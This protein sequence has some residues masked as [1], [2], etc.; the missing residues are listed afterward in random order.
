MKQTAIPSRFIST[1][2]INAI[3]WPGRVRTG[4]MSSSTGPMVATWPACAT[5][6][7]KPSSSSS[8]PKAS[9][10]GPSLWCSSGC[11]GCSICAPI[12]WSGLSM[13]QEIMC[14]GLSSMHFFCFRR[15][16]WSD[17]TFR[18]SA[19]FHPASV[20]AP[21]Q[22]SRPWRC[23]ARHLKQLSG[24]IN[25][26]LIHSQPARPVRGVGLLCGPFPADRLRACRRAR[27][28]SVAILE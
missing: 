26:Y 13:K 24:A 9:M 28:R 16:S 7:G 25:F 2:T 10:S 21:F 1:V 11:L 4:A 12:H 14:A 17:S 8:G 20:L 15:R 3:F 18:A 27:N 6:N 23:C 5:I 22:S 19:N